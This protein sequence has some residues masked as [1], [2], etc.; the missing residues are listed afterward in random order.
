M[1]ENQLCTNH[2]KTK[3]K[4]MDSDAINTHTSSH[5]TNKISV[6]AKSVESLGFSLNFDS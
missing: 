2:S 6:T 1:A 3:E 5:L 4:N